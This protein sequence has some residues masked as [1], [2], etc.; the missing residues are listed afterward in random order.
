ML[1]KVSVCPGLACTSIGAQSIDC[2][3]DK[4][5]VLILHSYHKGMLWA[6]SITSGIDE[7]LPFDPNRIMHI[8]YMDTKRNVSAEYLRD[9]EDFYRKKYA[10][11]KI[12]IIISA[13]DNAFNFAL[14]NRKEL[15]NDAPLVFCG[16]NY[17]RPEDFSNYSNF[18]GI[19][20]KND[21]L[22]TLNLAFALHKNASSIY[23]INDETTTGKANRK[24]LE[25]TI[26]FLNK[27]IEVK[28]SGSLP[29]EKLKENIKALPANAII[30]LLSYNRDADG[31]IFTYREISMHVK[32]VA[33]NPV[34]SVWD[35]YF[36]NG[37]AI[38]GC[39]T[40]GF[41]QGVIAAK[42]AKMILNGE[43]ADNIPVIR[44]PPTRYMFDYN[45]LADFGISLDALPE[46]SII[47]NKPYSLYRDNPVLFWQLALT[48]LLFSCLIG[49]L[50]L[51]VFKLLASR[52]ELE[53]GRQSLNIT[54]NSIAEAVIATNSEGKIVR[55][56]PHAEQLTG[57]P[58]SQALNH[59]LS[60][61]FK[62]KNSATNEV[63]ENLEEKFLTNYPKQSL[64]KFDSLINRKGDSIP[65]SFSI[66]PITDGYGVNFGI[67]VVFRDMTEENLIQE[68]LRQSQKMDAIGQLAGGVAHDFNNALTGIIG[69]VQLLE[70]EVNSEIGVKVLKLIEKSANRAAD[71]TAK[72][73]AFIRKGNFETAPHDFHSIIQASIDILG[74]TI[75]PRIVIKKR[76]EAHNSVING[77]FSELESVL[78]NIGINASHAM[79]DGGLLTYS[80]QNL[81]LDE[82]YCKKSSFSLIPGKYILLEISDTGCGIPPENLPRIFEPFFTT[83]EPGKGTG[84]GLSAAYG[85]IVQHKGAINAYSEPGRG[86]IFRIYLPTINSIAVF[87]EKKYEIVKGSGTILL[88]D[89]EPTVRFTTKLLLEEAGYRVL[90]AQTGPE[91]IEIL[92]QNKSHIDLVILDMIM[93]EMSGSDC[94]YSLKS[95]APELKIILCSGYSQDADLA[96]LKENGL[97][98]FVFKPC[99][100]DELSRVVAEV[101]NK[102]N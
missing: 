38:G 5:H 65:I 86:S 70:K 72:L 102:K 78:L 91:G 92:K 59:K 79:P 56:N 47:L 87:D 7:E 44:K 27:S 95:I 101:I 9:L 18:T 16:V 76:L 61:V 60:E 52:K 62:L 17:F 81:Y 85:T 23:V 21:Y 12:S 49:G 67:V 89:D 75:D 39:I 97:D 82:S 93:P 71:L 41:E 90:V 13:D 10:K 2:H 53:E 11:V 37:C 24:A 94:F 58:P 98:A 19:V 83:K 20:E 32:E 51:A 28:F 64:Q 8:E 73:L 96:K 50:T 74:R 80:T 26:M 45:R 77:N 14:K 66:S 15:F 4:K 63:C 54:L 34:Y 84:L 3:S 6:D 31:R 29:I 46:G 25:E 33:R 68:K 69:S 57:W 55:M 43:K 42:M 48:I 1:K 99:R 22:K 100:G 35:F 36:H 40:R 88:I 30:L